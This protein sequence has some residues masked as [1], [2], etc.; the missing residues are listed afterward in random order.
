MA[1][2]ATNRFPGDG[3]TTS[4]EFNFV[5]KYID[6]SHVKVYQEDNATKVRTHVSIN[7]G[8][9]LND[10]TLRNLPVT[11]VGSTLVIYRATPK[12][13]LVDFV[14]G[15][16]FTE[17]NMDL[18]ARQ[19]LFVAMEAID[20]AQLAGG[21]VG[22]AGWEGP[23][24]PVGPQGPQGIQGIPGSPG[25]PG[26]AGPQGPQ[27]PTGPAGPQG[28]PGSSSGSVGKRV[29]VIGD[30]LSDQ[31]TANEPS[32]PNIWQELML[33]VGEVTTLFNC[34]RGGSSFYRARTAAV[35]GSK[36][37]V[38]H[39]IDQSPE[40]VFVALGFND[41][42]TE[43]DGRTLAQQQQDA[44]DLFTALRTGLPS[45][46]II[47]V[48]LTPHDT[49][50]GSF[51]LTTFK[52]KYIIPAYMV[53]PSSG[54]NAGLLGTHML[55]NAT[56]IGVATKFH[57]WTQ[58]RQHV[59]ALPQVNYS[60]E[61]SL[62][63]ATRVAG[64]SADGLHPTYLASK[65]IASQVVTLCR[66][67][68]SVWPNISAGYS[69]AW[70]DLNGVFDGVLQS[71]GDGWVERSYDVA[72]ESYLVLNNLSSGIAG[73]RKSWWARSGGQIGFH[74]PATLT[75]DI[76]NEM[77]FV[78]ERCWP[79]TPVQFSL[80]G[81]AWAGSSSTDEGGNLVSS[82]ATMGFPAGSYEFY[83]RCGDEVWGPF[84]ITITPGSVRLDRTKISL[85]NRAEIVINNNATSQSVPANTE[86][87]VLMSNVIRSNK[88]TVASSV[89]TTPSSELTG[90][91]R[92]LVNFHA[93]A[94]LTASCAYFY[95][96]VRVNGT[97]RISGT[98]NAVYNPTGGAYIGSSGSEVITLNP[99]DTIDL[100]V[101]SAV[102]TNTVAD[103][104]AQ[105]LSITQLPIGD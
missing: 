61:A 23:P 15:S 55:D 47:F 71:S 87:R 20:A 31:Y 7:D 103:A 84:N 105:R 69:G 50:N 58:L 81:S 42:I 59:A 64:S 53:R 80:A 65:L 54:L 43:I 14:N 75:N 88:F 74:T 6:R 10:T 21:S 56:G 49:S 5:G 48:Q 36:T 33:G 92:Y 63:K 96:W 102:A 104:G 26:P 3:S 46:T 22:G 78:A 93:A 12:P 4:Y 98:Y 86:T 101:V 17:Y 39:C 16:L 83:Y 34:S 60:V 66:A 38:Q 57:N 45:A 37:Q 41:S 90:A 9:F 1:L 94:N 76:G 91:A 40:V 29:A 28:V 11:P 77:L 19:G 30:S 82:A 44:T 97:R 67:L 18:V 95:A 35:F 68:T 52:N 72:R 24:G 73:R 85:G 99:G 32:W 79:N 89:V 70:A 13:P 62:W 8:N 2:Y 25:G 51:P 27:G 100:M